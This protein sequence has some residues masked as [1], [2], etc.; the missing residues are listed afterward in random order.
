[1]GNVGTAVV[2]RL[3]ADG[4]ARIVAGVE[5]LP[6]GF[7]S[8]GR[9]PLAYPRGLDVAPDGT[10]YI[11]DNGALLR[12]PPGGAAE[13]VA[14]RDTKVGLLNSVTF[15]GVRRLPD[16]RLVARGLGQQKEMVLQQDA[17]GGPWRVALSEATRWGNPWNISM[18]AWDV[19]SDGTIV[20][21]RHVPKAQSAD[22]DAE[23][24]RLKPGEAE[25]SVLVP[26]SAG[27]N[28]IA[29]LVFAPDGTLHLR[30]R[31]AW[32]DPDKTHHFIVAED[33]TLSAAPAGVLAAEA[34]DAQGRLYEGDAS[35]YTLGNYGDRR[36]RRQAPGQPAEVV[37]GQGSGL[38]GG[39][40]LDDSIG[41]AEDLRFDAAGNLYVRDVLRRQVRRI[42][43]ERL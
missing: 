38:L 8:D 25:A 2:R 6:K 5:G 42:P 18:H 23:V 34:R 16:G 26:V 30:G 41:W 29:R 43:R 37:A 11:A 24:Y 17:P 20:V 33:G 9:I 36:I 39:A 31:K 15:T 40:T 12:V 32:G 3:G 13:V 10:L 28:E 35:A 7:T 14:A 4:T 22:N 1:V 19:A 21:S 27:L